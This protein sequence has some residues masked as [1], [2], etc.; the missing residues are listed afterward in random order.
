[1]LKAPTLVPSLT[2]TLAGVI[3]GLYGA[4]GAIAAW[5]TSGMDVPVGR[6]VVLFVGG[7]MFAVGAM[8]LLTVVVRPFFE[9]RPVD[10]IADEIKDEQSRQSRST[11]A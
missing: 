5:N 7:S 1:M 6:M 11:D 9:K 3:L 8:M 10:R 2:L 4:S